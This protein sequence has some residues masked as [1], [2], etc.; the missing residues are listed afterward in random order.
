[1][2]IKVEDPAHIDAGPKTEALQMKVSSGSESSS[3]ASE[4]KSRLTPVMP[5]QKV[6]FWL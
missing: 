4:P 5:Q 1:M 3:S 6:L 2:K